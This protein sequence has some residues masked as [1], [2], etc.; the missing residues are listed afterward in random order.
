MTDIRN[1]APGPY[2]WETSGK[3][4][5][6]GDFNVY[7]IDADGRKIAAVWGKRG[8]KVWTCSL[9]ALSLEFFEYVLAR[10]R[11]GDVEAQRLVV[12]VD[13]SAKEARAA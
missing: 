13:E 10:S 7:V 8:E 2:A 6:N 3:P 12:L 1:F 5:G 9:M 4:G 11:D